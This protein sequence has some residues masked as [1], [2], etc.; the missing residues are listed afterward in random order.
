LTDKPVA[1]TVVFFPPSLNYDGLM[2]AAHLPALAPFTTDDCDMAYGL[3]EELTIGV[4]KQLYSFGL[5]ERLYQN[6]SGRFSI[7]GD[8]LGKGLRWCLD[9]EGVFPTLLNIFAFCDGINAVV[10]AGCTERAVIFATFLSQPTSKGSVDRTFLGQLKVNVNYM[11]T[12][13]DRQAMFLAFKKAEAI[14]A[15]ITG[16]AVLERPG[17]GTCPTLFAGDLPS[18][19]GPA[20]LNNPSISTDDPIEG[21]DILAERVVAAHHFCGTAA[22]GR[23]VDHRFRVKGIE[24]LY[25]ADAS[26]LPMTPPVNTMASTLMLGR[27]AGVYAVDEMTR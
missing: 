17:P 4:A 16:A 27:L 2:T 11:D 7:V 13:N 14:L 15:G 1:P 5:Y 23:V 8:A 21:G 9:R 19:G 25:V 24:G 10:D 20:T 6:R 3:Y 18:S 26:V 12:P 22:F